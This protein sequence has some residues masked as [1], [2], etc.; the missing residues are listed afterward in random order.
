MEVGGR[1]RQGAR[2]KRWEE[3]VQGTDRE[4]KGMV[5]IPAA[6]FDVVRWMRVDS[7]C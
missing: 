1:M 5:L 4:V 6:W 3:G 2:W 7:D